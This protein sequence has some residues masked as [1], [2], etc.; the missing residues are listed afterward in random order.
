APLASASI[1]IAAASCARRVTSRTV[2][3][4]A[5]LGSASPRKPSVVT[6]SSWS[7]VD[8]L[9]VPCRAKA[10]S[11]SSPSMPS[12]SSRTVMRSMPPPRR[13]TSTWRAPA[14]SAFSTSSFTTD[15]GR[16]ITS[17]AAICPC[18]TGGGMATFP[19][20]HVSGSEDEA[21]ILPRH[22]GVDLG[23]ARL[24][25]RASHQAEGE[26]FG[27]LDGRLPKRSDAGEPAGCHGRHLEEVDQLPDR[28]RIH[29]RERE[30]R[31]RAGAPRE[32]QLGGM[33]RA[34]QERPQRVA[35]ETANLLDVLVRGGDVER[36]AV[37]LD[38]Q[39]DHHLV[40]RPL[41]VELE[42][43]VLVRASAPPPGGLPALDPASLAV[44]GLAETLPPELA[45]PVADRGQP[46]GVAHEDD[47]A[48]AVGA[49]QRPQRARQRERRIGE[50]RFGG[51]PRLFHHWG[52]G[53]R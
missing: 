2:P 24:E 38:A 26:F 31:A 53:G 46:L 14:S 22:P 21:R 28:E 44:A 25:S 19:T 29:R 52:P 27:L 9:L 16:S 5:M 10:R 15:A 30:G 48:L 36:L 47:D 33:L 42:V 3:A 18:T 12:P 11:A 49:R 17:P 39:E 8:S 4:A 51:S 41:Q 50:R 37:V 34:V 1:V 45:E 13:L 40:A 20:R 32:R 23:P 6:P 7:R 43:R 35:A